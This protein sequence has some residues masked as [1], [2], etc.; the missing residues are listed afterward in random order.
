MDPKQE[1]K[2]KHVDLREEVQGQ[3]NIFI[4]AAEVIDH[5]PHLRV[6]ELEPHVGIYPP[7][8]II[9]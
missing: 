1:S 9:I 4:V 7:S 8:S 5:Q 6:E 2:S 3:I